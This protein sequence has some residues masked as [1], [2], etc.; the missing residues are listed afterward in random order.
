[1]ES[2]FDLFDLIALGLGDHDSKVH[3]KHW[4]LSCLLESEYSPSCAV[5]SQKH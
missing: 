2:F 5:F 3:S 1:M 4:E